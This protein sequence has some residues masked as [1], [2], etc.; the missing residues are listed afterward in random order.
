[1]RFFCLS[2]P[3]SCL[4]VQHLPLLPSL[5]QPEGERERDFWY[6]FWQVTAQSYRSLRKTKFYPKKVYQRGGLNP[7]RVFVVD[8]SGFTSFK[9]DLKYMAFFF[10]VGRNHLR[11]SYTSQSWLRSFSIGTS[12]NISVGTTGKN[13]CGNWE[14]GSGSDLCVQK[15]LRR[16]QLEGQW[17]KERKGKVGSCFKE[18]I[19]WKNVKH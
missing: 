16:H 12:W 10:L 11:H 15:S 14:E 5:S 9:F 17:G 3:I 1:M 18:R 7:L 4:Y 8:G 2:P 13:F 19:F 6:K